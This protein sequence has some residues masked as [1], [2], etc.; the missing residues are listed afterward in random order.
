M[1]TMSRIA[2]LMPVA[3]LAACSGALP[4][5]ADEAYTHDALRADAAVRVEPPPSLPPPSIDLNRPAQPAGAPGHTSCH[6][7]SGFLTDKD[8]AGRIVRAGPA[9]DAAELGRIPPPQYSEDAGEDWPYEFSIVGSQDGWLEIE[10]AGLDEQIA[11]KAER[12]AYTGRGWIAGGGVLVAVQSGTGFAAPSHDSAV[13]V[14]AHPNDRALEEFGPKRVIGC[15]GRWVLADWDGAVR[16]DG[17][18]W[19][20]TYRPE[21]VVRRNPVV[22]RA[23]SAGVCNILETT[24]D[25]MNGDFADTSGLELTD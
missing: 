2:P 4:G 7:I 13:L 6:G 12:T 16:Y 1:A 21:A 17:E 18:T 3:A 11:G 8:P 15:S 23:W 25:G 22:L 5:L 24:C 19:R 20:L 9:R 10:G 14:S